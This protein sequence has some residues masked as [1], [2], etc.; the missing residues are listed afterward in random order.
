[1]GSIDSLLMAAAM[2]LTGCPRAYQRRAIFGFMAFDFLASFAG[3]PISAMATTT[4][5]FAF[6]FSFAIIFVGK[7]KPLLYAFV[8][9][10]CCVDNLF[11]DTS[12]PF[13]VWSAATDS[14]TSGALAWIGFWS[15]TV[16]ANRK[17]T[18][19]QRCAQL[20]IRWIQFRNAN[21]SFIRYFSTAPAAAFNR[22]YCQRDYSEVKD[23]RRYQ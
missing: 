4:V 15:V 18:F 10:L 6:V 14:I 22:G 3:L 2:A 20:E 9:I 7:H 8:P 16:S 13:R 23:W 21:G 11:A 1:M 5:T 12:V 17:Y 19:R